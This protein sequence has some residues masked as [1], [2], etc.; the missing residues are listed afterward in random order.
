MLT[1]MSTQAELSTACFPESLD[2]MVDLHVLDYVMA[3]SI[4]SKALQRNS[5]A[6]SEAATHRIWAFRR[7][8]EQ[9]SIKASFFTFLSDFYAPECSENF[10]GGFHVFTDSSGLGAEEAFCGQLAQAVLL[11]RLRG[12][13]GERL[14]LAAAAH[15]SSALTLAL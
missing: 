4:I 6:R 12:M 7:E 2:E 3:G 14:G 11:L 15:H 9:S 10:S 1:F 8:S 5:S 13:V